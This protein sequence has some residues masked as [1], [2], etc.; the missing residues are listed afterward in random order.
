MEDTTSEHSLDL[1]ISSVAEQKV[2]IG[3]HTHRE[4]YGKESSCILNDGSDRGGVLV[5]TIWTMAATCP[6]YSDC[7]MTESGRTF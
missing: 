4:L 5:T 1:I 6:R 3:R 2:V 7:D